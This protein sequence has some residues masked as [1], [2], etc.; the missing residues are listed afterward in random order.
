VAASAAPPGV[1]ITPLA[2]RTR[3]IMIDSM[4]M[5]SPRAKRS[6]DLELEKF[7]MEK[8]LE[9]KIQELND[10]LRKDQGALT[11][12]VK[13]AQQRETEL[14]A[15]LAGANK[16]LKELET[17]IRVLQIRQKSELT[18]V[19]D[20]HAARLQRAQAATADAAQ[21]SAAEGTIATLEEEISALQLR[22]SVVAKE[23]D[24]QQLVFNKMQQNF[25]RADSQCAVATDRCTAMEVTLLEV[26]QESDTMFATLKSELE[27]AD[28]MLKV[29]LVS[30]VVSRV[31]SFHRFAVCVVLLCGRSNPTAMR[32]EKNLI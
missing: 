24:E 18:R 17:T 19:N 31:L 5:Q 29:R 30:C 28:A 27:A 21:N 8:E 26:Q 3:G 32:C 11:T 9:G 13:A 12:V 16:S 4:D 20:E 14:Q 2:S 15:E 6:A 1:P 23:V 10:Q 25:N 7:K 22:A